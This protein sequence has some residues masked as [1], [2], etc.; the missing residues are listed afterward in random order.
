MK[1]TAK[2]EE[3]LAQS[4]EGD[5]GCLNTKRREKG[6]E[7]RGSQVGARSFSR[8]FAYLGDRQIF[9]LINMGMNDCRAATA[10]NRPMLGAII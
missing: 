10:S 4:P 7:T 5:W 1:H 9:L 6:K 2:N 3:A 8:H